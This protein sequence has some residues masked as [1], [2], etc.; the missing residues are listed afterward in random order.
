MSVITNDP[1]TRMVCCAV[2]RWPPTQNSVSG[3]GRKWIPGEKHKVREST[4]HHVI[5]K[6]PVIC[7]DISGDSVVISLQQT[8][9]S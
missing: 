3:K 2:C 8:D 7:G 6:P 4:V 9:F 5:S 1:H